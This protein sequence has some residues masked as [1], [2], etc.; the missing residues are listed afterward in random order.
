MK[1]KL[2]GSA[3]AAVLCTF[4]LLPNRIYANPPAYNVTQLRLGNPI[5][6]S[7]GYG[8]N[9]SGQ[10]AGWSA[11]STTGDGAYHAVRWTGTTPEDL[12][13]LGG[14]N[15]YG[16]AINASGQVAGWSDITGDGGYHAVVWTGTTLT[17]LGTLGGSFSKAYG[18]NSFGDVI[19]TSTTAGRCA[20]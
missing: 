15:S 8:I 5:N 19:G 17:D 20:T 14:T 2:L 16:Y 10:V 7:Y 4:T 9:A 6:P 13:T 12:G 11:S 1:T 3:S 18:I